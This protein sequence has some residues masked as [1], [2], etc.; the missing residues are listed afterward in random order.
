M[1]GI[2]FHVPGDVVPWARAGKHGK[3]QFTP[4]KQRNYMGVIRDFCSQA[5]SDRPLFEGPVRLTIAAVYPWPKTVTKKRLASID[6]AWKST[7]PDGDNIAKIVKDSMNKIAFVD[8]AQC[9][10]T[11]VFKVYGDKPGLRVTL[12]SLEGIQAPIA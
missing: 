1:N 11:T 5:M 10:V 3:V 12:E 6:G 9:A 2:T 7:K 8:D 4:G